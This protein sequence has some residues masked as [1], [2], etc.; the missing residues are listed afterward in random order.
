LLQINYFIKIGVID[1]T[2]TITIRTLVEAG[3]VKKVKYGVKLLGKG[4]EKIDYPL[5][6]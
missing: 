2:K 6:L 1:A 3:L 5:N 4:L